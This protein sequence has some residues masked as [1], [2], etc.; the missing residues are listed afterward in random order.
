[1]P[2][3]ETCKF[4]NASDV[5]PRDVLDAVV[6][7]ACLEWAEAIR[8]LVSV[9]WLVHEINACTFPD[10]TNALQAVLTLKTVPDDVYVDMRG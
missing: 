3:V 4:I 10:E 7:S 6:V 8:L 5:L 2:K 9:S 1:M